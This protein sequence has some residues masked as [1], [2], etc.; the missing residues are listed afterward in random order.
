MRFFIVIIALISIIAVAATVG[1]V[2][3]GS[4]SFE[5]IV[6]DKPYEAGLAW[7]EMHRNHDKLGWTIAVAGEPFRTGKNDLIVTIL[8]KRGAPLGDADVTITVTRPSTRAFDRTYQAD[9][10]PDGRYRASAELARQGNWDLI[11]DVSRKTD[12][13]SFKKSIFAEPDEK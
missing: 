8:D 1:T 11:I 9:V 13:T 2:I 3:V 7:D 5:G 4:R 12:H 6:V 10:Q